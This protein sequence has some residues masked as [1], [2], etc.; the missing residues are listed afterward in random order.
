MNMN[1][2]ELKKNR[3][4]RCAREVREKSIPDEGMEWKPSF[5]GGESVSDILFF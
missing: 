3:D 5:Q 1:K 4:K 2:H